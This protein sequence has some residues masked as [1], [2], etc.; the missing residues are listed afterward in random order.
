MKVA[1]VKTS[2]TYTIWLAM[3]TLASLVVVLEHWLA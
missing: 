3:A 1:G 2:I